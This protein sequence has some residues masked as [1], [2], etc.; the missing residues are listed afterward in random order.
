[1]CVCLFGLSPSTPPMDQITLKE[2]RTLWCYP[3]NPRKHFKTIFPDHAKKCENLRVLCATQNDSSPWISETMDVLFPKNMVSFACA[4][5]TMTGLKKLV[6]VRPPLRTLHIVIPPFPKA[7][8]L[9]ERLIEGCVLT[10]E[11]L[12]VKTWC[13]GRGDKTQT[14]WHDP[15]RFLSLLMKISPKLKCLYVRGFPLEIPI[16]GPHMANIVASHAQ[17]ITTSTVPDDCDSMIPLLVP[18][19]K[20]EVFADNVAE[21]PLVYRC[22]DLAPL[23][24]HVHTLVFCGDIVSEGSHHKDK[25]A[26]TVVAMKQLRNVWVHSVGCLIHPQPYRDKRTAVENW[27]QCDHLETLILSSSEDTDD[28]WCLEEWLGT[29]TG[30]KNLGLFQLWKENR[31]LGGSSLFRLPPHL[32]EL[33]VRE[34]WKTLENLGNQ[35]ITYSGVSTIRISGYDSES[36]DNRVGAICEKI[37]P[38]AKQILW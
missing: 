30:L 1:V 7:Q 27:R 8:D 2:P 16:G 24:T 37:F 3:R 15:Q 4:P 23:F 20:V 10:L 36:D 17:C 9:L 31:L 13:R 11:D 38:N 25:I 12:V 6:S 33:S 22:M 28:V 5:V 18:E 34:M 21:L 35:D 19:L 26:S 29:L 14:P 32:E